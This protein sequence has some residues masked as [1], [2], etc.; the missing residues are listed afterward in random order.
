M[1]LKAQ[2]ESNLFLIY[3]IVR[4]ADADGES[5][6]ESELHSLRW[7][8]CGHTIEEEDALVDEP[9]EPTSE[10]SS[11]S[12]LYR[13]AARHLSRAHKSSCASDPAARSRFAAAYASLRGSQFLLGSMTHRDA[14][15]LS[16]VGALRLGGAFEFASAIIGVFAT[17]Y[18]FGILR[19]SVVA[20]CLL[21][22]G[23]AV[24]VAIILAVR[25]S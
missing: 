16:V 12:P 2:V 24:V 14:P 10:G 8:V 19:P 3:E 13:K 7:P 21:I 23:I 20:S 11:F 22:G 5:Y 18:S 1:D 15:V 17:P 25:L 4:Q 6:S 9:D